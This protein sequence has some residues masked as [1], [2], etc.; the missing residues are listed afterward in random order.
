MNEEIL[1]ED[2]IAICPVCG[3][4]FIVTPK[5]SIYC[6]DLCLKQVSKKSEK[7]LKSKSKVK[8]CK[9]CGKLFQTNRYAPNQKYCCQDCYYRSVMKTTKEEEPKE[10]SEPRRVVCTKCGVAFRTARNTTLCPLCREL[11]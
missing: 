9:G 2:R 5:H 10:H 11:R 4:E 8:E 7:K 3:G 1:K 6:S